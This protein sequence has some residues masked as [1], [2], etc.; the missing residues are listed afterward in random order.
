[1][2]RILLIGCAG[3]GKSTLAP[4]I[5]QKLGLPC[6]HLD[7][8]FWKPGWVET[9]QAEWERKL[10]KI[11]KAKKWVMDGHY[12]GT[13]LL[14]FKYADTILFFDFNRWICLWRVLGRIA[15]TYGRTR[16][17]MAPGC[18]EQFDWGFLVW[19]WDFNNGSRPATLERLKTL[20]KKQ[21]LVILRTPGE[22]ADF[23]N[24]L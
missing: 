2:K 1:M 14:R 15:K 8:L 24:N 22:A 4:K 9:P 13:Q 20:K 5:A 23:L 3:A 7:Q 10:K 21:R 12:G 18:K 16:V 11:M 19:I 6:I 17:D